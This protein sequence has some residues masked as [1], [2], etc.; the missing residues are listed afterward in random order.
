MGGAAAY[1][2][3]A[4]AELGGAD[5]APADQRRRIAYFIN[6]FPNR[7]E[8]MIYREVQALEA[9]GYQ[10]VPFSIRAPAPALVPA[11]ARPLADRTRYL[12]PI[13][14]PRLVWR[15]MEA[16]WR[17]GVRYVRVLA[18]IITG[19]HESWRDRLRSLCHFAEAVSVLPE[20]E[21]LRPDHLHAH[22]AVGATTC[23]M[24]ASRFLDLP[25]TFTAHAYDI[26]RERLLLPEKLAAARLAVTCTAANRQ[27]LIARYG[28]P[29]ER[30][31]V[32]HHGLRLERFVPP[33]A[34]RNAEPVIVSVG[35]LV[36][37]K[38]FADLL[39]ACA[40]LRR[41]GVA[42]R[43]EIAGDG[44]LRQSLAAHA[45]ALG[46]AGQV[47]WLGALDQEELAAR[48]AG[49]DVFALL[50]V[51][52]SDDDRDGIPNTMIEAMAMELPCVST[53]FSGV[54]ELVIEGETGVLVEIGDVAGAA[55][56]LAG[57]FADPARRRA[58]GAA[59][60]RRVVEAFTIERSAAN[61]AAAFEE[62]C[63]AAEHDGTQRD[64]R[65]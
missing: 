53:R 47:R 9:L 41:R 43:C 30:V 15:H 31:R 32:V 54:P 58:M 18:E 3:D 57:L 17:H 6:L 45:V 10:V 48:Y 36:E 19:T 33:A 1:P 34:R 29:P 13:S 2:R 21:R 20:I 64:G 37:Q 46:V 62:I 35:R 60:R 65:G 40:L 59:G 16:L 11:D 49:A 39:A 63:A 5:G 4:E 27:H 12:L 23:A 51:P 52:A 25:F 42:F 28:A 55:D 50:C 56:A 44:P 8:T 14:A 24:V 38:G 61:L 7:I 26:W 22:W